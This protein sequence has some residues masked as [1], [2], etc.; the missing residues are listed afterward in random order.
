MDIIFVCTGNTCR[1]PIA[2][3]LMKK[4]LH[5]K[6]IDSISVTSAGLAAYSGDE[7]SEKSVKAAAEYGIDISSHRSRRISEYMLESGIFVCMTVAHAQ[8][9]LPYTDKNRLFILGNGIADP[10]GG[11]QEDY[12]I[13]AE[14]IN[15]A[16]PYLLRSIISLNTAIEPME[17]EHIEKIAEIEEK[18]FSMPWSEKSLREELNNENAHFL[19]AILESQV[20]GYIGAIEICGEADITNVAVLPEYRRCGIGE[21]LL[22]FAENG[23]KGRGCESITLE[24]RASNTAAISLYQKAGY[25]QAG[26]RKNF[27]EKPTEDAL[28]MTKYFEKGQDQ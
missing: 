23:A 13:C 4:I 2:E 12:D 10:Y 1:S 24:V 5:D 26:T 8:A 19:A 15:A 22:N 9:L 7:A 17:E 27:Y 3:G 20:I 28:L 21:K 16:L 11:T 14:Q 18:C 25:Q 6:G